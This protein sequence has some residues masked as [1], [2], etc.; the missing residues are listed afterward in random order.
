MK[1]I[2][3]N[4][5]GDGAVVFL[6]AEGWVTDIVDSAVLNA[7]DA[8]EAGFVTAER[9]ASEQ[10][11]VGVEAIEVSLDENRSPVPIRLRERIRAFGPTVR[12]GEAARQRLVA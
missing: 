8:I 11:I 2:T 9:S 10:E 12:Y 1:I 7:P 4:R 5:L 6:S 3:A